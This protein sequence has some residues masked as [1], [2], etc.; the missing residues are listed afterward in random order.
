MLDESHGSDLEMTGR[1]Q[2]GSNDLIFVVV[3]HF[4]ILT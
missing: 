3:T 1:L 2:T 4:K